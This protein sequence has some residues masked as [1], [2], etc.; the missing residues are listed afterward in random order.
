MDVAVQTPVPLTE[1]FCQ[2]LFP[3]VSLAE[4]LTLVSAAAAMSGFN[5]HAF[6]A[7][8]DQALFRIKTILD[9][10]RNPQLPAEVPHEYTDKYLLV[11]FIANTGRLGSLPTLVSFL[12]H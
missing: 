6:R 1:V 12:Q 9:N 10:T 2:P 11:E 8:V 3:S 7:N 5:E 4:I